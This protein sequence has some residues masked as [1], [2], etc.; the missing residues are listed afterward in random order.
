MGRNNITSCKLTCV[1][2]I[3]GTLNEIVKSTQDHGNIPC[4]HGIRE[5]VFIHDYGFI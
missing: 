1:D 5:P 3:P 2:E 4:K